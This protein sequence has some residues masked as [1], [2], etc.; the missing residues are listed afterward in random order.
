MQ[1]AQSTRDCVTLGWWEN[2]ACYATRTYFQDSYFFC[3][4]T[5]LKIEIEM[6]SFKAPSH[7][8]VCK[9]NKVVSVRFEP[10]EALKI[11]CIT[12]ALQTFHTKW[13]KHIFWWQC[14]INSY[15]L[16]PIVSMRK[17][18]VWKSHDCPFFPF[19][20]PDQSPPEIVPFLPAGTWVRRSKHEGWSVGALA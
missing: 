3:N 13:S 6:S 7:D 18:Q 19:P 14:R 2:F 17:V 12:R 9:E 15:P 4:I 20:Q 5:M 10:F 1:I 8:E 16:V 11:C